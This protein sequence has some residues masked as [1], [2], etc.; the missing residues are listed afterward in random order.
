MGKIRVGYDA[1][2]LFFAQ[3]GTKT[4]SEE[5]IR[6]IQ[7][8]QSV[9]LMLLSPE[10][11]HAPKSLISKAWSHIQFITWKLWTLPQKAQ[12]ERIDFLIC[13]DYVAPFLFL[14][15]IKTLP[16][17]HGCN[18]WELPKNY[19]AVWRWYFSVL[20]K[21]GKNSAHKILT[22]SEFSKSR[23]QEVLG[24]D[25]KRIKTIPIGAK[26]VSIPDTSQIKRPIP[27]DYLL[28]IGVLDKRKNLPNL[29]KALV[30]LENKEA[31]LVLVGGRP[32]KLFNDD[33]PEIIKTINELGIESR[34][35]LK[36][37][38]PD[39][40]L[41]AYYQN[42]RA[43]VFPS[44][45]EGFGIPVLE[46]YQHGL[47]LAASNTASLPEVV[48]D[49]G[50]LFDPRDIENIAKTIDKLLKLS[51]EELSTLKIGQEKALAWFNWK[52]AWQEIKNTFDEA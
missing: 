12:K 14:R 3:T 28:H 44:I 42:A 34:V 19:N 45:Y 23:L 10:N 26:K 30:L 17:F 1:R 25:P 41:S 22:V 39:E 4:F 32:S 35:H 20:A 47:P 50:L 24:F 5:L 8:D 33:Y 51:E 52:N 11:A 36:G 29:I 7:K 49:G 15:N 31:H 21:H 46:A 40:E 9:D 27:Q 48:G 6:E 18:I 13:P 38:I 2:D 43:Y 16:V 37:Y